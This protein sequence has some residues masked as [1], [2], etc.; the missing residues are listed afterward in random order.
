[1]T[2]KCKDIPVPLSFVPKGISQGRKEWFINNQLD[3]LNTAG[4]NEDTYVE[5]NANDFISMLL[6]FETN[7]RA[8]FLR[9]HFATFGNAGTSNVP[10][11]Y[12][13]KMTIV[14]APLE[15]REDRST[16]FYM[17]D[18]DGSFHP[19]RSKLPD[20][21]ADRWIKNYEQKQL[22]ILSNHVDKIP[23]NKNTDSN[24]PEYSDTRSV[25]YGMHILKPLSTE[26][27]CQAAAKVRIYFSAYKGNE[28]ATPY[29][30][31]KRMVTQIE[32]VDHWDND[33]YIDDF[34]MSCRPVVSDVE[35]IRE[36]FDNGQLCPTNCPR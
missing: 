35:K 28:T 2:C 11:G 5:F 10:F 18:P 24:V 14:Y 13:N 8:N 33:L 30:V 27:L 15:K 32:L 1:M 21:I 6:S 7:E 36:G 19:L 4:F 20:G 31:P 29:I 16:I 23:E 3:H 17:S 26:V 12:E 9:I 22:I 25:L 34:D